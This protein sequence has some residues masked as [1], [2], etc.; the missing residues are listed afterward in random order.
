MPRLPP[1][2]QLH[3]GQENGRGV[4]LAVQA[5]TAVME[6]LPTNGRRSSICRSNPRFCRQNSRCLSPISVRRSMR[7][8]PAGVS[9]AGEYRLFLGGIDARLRPSSATVPVREI[10]S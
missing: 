4:A 6:G 9:V 5:S 7:S 3:P 1:I 2:S 8:Y 10:S